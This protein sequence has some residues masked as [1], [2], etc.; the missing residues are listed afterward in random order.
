[1]NRVSLKNNFEAISRVFW[2]KIWKLEEEE[3]AD[4]TRFHM[5]AAEKIE[6]RAGEDV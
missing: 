1:M 5:Y 2:A 6:I 3:S 4:P